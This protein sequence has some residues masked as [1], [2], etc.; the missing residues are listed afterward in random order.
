MSHFPR[1]NMMC[2]LPQVLRYRNLWERATAWVLGKLQHYVPRDDE[3][4]LSSPTLRAPFSHMTHLIKMNEFRPG[5]ISEFMSLCSLQNEIK[6]HMFTGRKCSLPNLI[7]QGQCA[8]QWA[9]MICVFKLLCGHSNNANILFINTCVCACLILRRVSYNLFVSWFLFAVSLSSDSTLL[10]NSKGRSWAHLIFLL[11]L[12][13][14]QCVVVYDVYD[15][16]K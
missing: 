14:L 8:H 13:L 1:P 5:L 10:N 11:L 3:I 15:K 4:L 16:N 12:S 7:F 2:V 9:G 6:Q